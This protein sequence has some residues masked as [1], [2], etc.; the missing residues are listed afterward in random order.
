[1]L[2]DHGPSPKEIRA[3]IQT[4]QEMMKRPLRDAA[5]CLAPHGLFRLISFRTPGPTALGLPQLK[6]VVPSPINGWIF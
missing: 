6:Q 2:S 5:Y 4:E 3:G 1:M